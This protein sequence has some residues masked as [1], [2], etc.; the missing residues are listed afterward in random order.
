VYLKC[1]SIEKG[2]KIKGYVRHHARVTLQHDVVQ[3]LGTPMCLIYNTNYIF[4]VTTCFVPEVL[5]KFCNIQQ[6]V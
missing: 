2:T 3:K 6:V 4:T 1:I 5:M